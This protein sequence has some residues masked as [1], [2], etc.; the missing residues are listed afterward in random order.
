LAIEPKQKIKDPFLYP[1]GFF[2]R[3][4]LAK[5]LSGSCLKPNF[6][7]R[8]TVWRWRLLA[9]PIKPTVGVVDSQNVKT[10]IG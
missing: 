8:E 9:K 4:Q 6:A 7:K 2:D 3:Y 5:I 1:I 10:F